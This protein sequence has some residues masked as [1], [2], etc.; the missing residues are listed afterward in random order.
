M[1][2]GNRAG[3]Y[4]YDFLDN[5]RR[6]S[7]T[8]IV[9]E[10]QHITSGTLFPAMPGVTEGFVVLLVEPHRSLVV[11]WPGP[12]RCPTVTWA[13]VLEP[14]G[15][16]TRLIVRVSAAA[17][18]RF[19]GLPAWLSDPAMRLGHFVMQR[20]QLLEIAW[21]AESSSGKIPETGLFPGIEGKF[22]PSDS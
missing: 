6:R 10:L 12:D 18:Y 15:D 19:H 5:G 2:A 16:A 11:G 9:P 21:R 3:W 1:G 22:A 7:A 14:R 4:S 8:R 17:R 20:K 13:F